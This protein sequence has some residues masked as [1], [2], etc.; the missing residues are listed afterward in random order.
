M[1]VRYEAAHAAVGVVRV[2]YPLLDLL[3]PVFA[4]RAVRR[5]PPRRWPT[6]LRKAGIGD[7]VTV[8]HL[9]ALKVITRHR[10]AAAA[11]AA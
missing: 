11:A 7:I 10:D 6:T 8:N 3:A 5:L 9:L 4:R 2:L 1:P